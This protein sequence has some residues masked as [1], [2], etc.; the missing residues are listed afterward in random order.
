M[1]GNTKLGAVLA[2]IGILTG[3]LAFYLLASTYNP[4]IT[5]KLG[6]RAQR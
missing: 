2:V 3:L 4:V 1:K 6:A 5:F